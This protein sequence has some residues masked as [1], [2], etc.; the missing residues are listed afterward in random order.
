LEYIALRLSV[1]Q[2]E[3]LLPY[4]ALRVRDNTVRL[5]KSFFVNETVK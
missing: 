5:K 3:V 2:E 4:L 1:T